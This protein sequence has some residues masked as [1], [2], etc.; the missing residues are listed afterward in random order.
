MITDNQGVRE[1]VARKAPDRANAEVSAPVVKP[2][3]SAW[4]SFGEVLDHGG[5][6]YL[7]FAITNI[8]NAQCDFCGFAVD[9]FDP[10]QRR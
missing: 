10:S 1:R 9:R 5:P 2:R 8:C 3:K 7:Q 4:R 6:G